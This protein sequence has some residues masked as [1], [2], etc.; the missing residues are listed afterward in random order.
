MR[1]NGDEQV[2]IELTERWEEHLGMDRHT[3]EP[4]SSN[5]FHDKNSSESD[6]ARLHLG[7]AAKAQGGELEER[8]WQ[9]RRNVHH[10]DGGITTDFMNQLL[11]T[12]GTAGTATAFLTMVKS[13]VT[14]WL[15]NSAS[16]SITVK[17][18]AT[19]VTIHGNNDID[20]AISALQ[21]LAAL[22]R[23]V[24]DK[25]KGRGVRKPATGD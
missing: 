21:K 6:S 15:R 8:Q 14:T 10:Y 19:A 16:R 11:V 13:V 3:G 18:G 25:P 20:S 24:P 4:I 22:E 5:S 12:F 7:Q 9:S 1:T 17:K 23:E 2:I